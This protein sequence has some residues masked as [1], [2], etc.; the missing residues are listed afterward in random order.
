MEPVDRRTV[1]A[2]DRTIL[3]RERT[4]AAWMRTGIAALASGVGARTLLG[5]VLP[6][7]MAITGGL[8]LTAF[9][10][11]CFVVAVWRELSPGYEDLSPD[12]RRLP[13]WVFVVLSTLLF[14]LTCAV[15]VAIVAAR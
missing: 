7:W 9:A 14:A 15:G 8:V 13:A 2:A 3:A 6:G 1:F 10:A 4:Y 5:G 12:V 11:L